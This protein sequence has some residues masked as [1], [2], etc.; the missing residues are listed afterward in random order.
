MT[1]ENKDPLLI[2]L[3]MPIETDRLFIRN[4]EPNDGQTIFDAKEETRQ[5]LLQWM[6]WSKEPDSLDISEK[7]CREN[8]AKFIRREDIMLLA[9]E[10][11][12][13]KM[14]GASGFP[15]FDW[16]TRRFEIGYWVRA[17]EQGK[18]YATEIT[19]ALT[20]YAFDALKANAVSIGYAVGNTRSARVVE[21]LDFTFEGQAKFDIALPN[22]EVVDSLTYSRTTL[23]GLPDLNVR[24]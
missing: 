21:K 23:D 8:Y 22:G 10:Q 18:G 14:L 16:A 5:H 13:Q 19:N 11:G 9:F 24:W 2:D 3:P 15:R 6:I 12:T 17:S 4:V 7:L 1:T 20:R